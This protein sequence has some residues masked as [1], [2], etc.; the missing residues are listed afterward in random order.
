MGR[1]AALVRKELEQHVAV[2]LGIA[3]F[4]P[5]CWALL[6]LGVF[7]APTTVTYVEVHATM[8]RFFV[9]LTGLAIANR[10]VVAEYHGRTQLFLEALPIGRLEV[11]FVKLGLGLVMLETVALGSLGATLLVASLREPIDAPFV[12]ILAA[13]T[14]AFAL[15]VWCFFFTMGLLGRLRF[16]I[17]LALLMLLLFIGTSTELEL[18]RFGPIALVAEDFP[19]ERTRL[20]TSALLETLTFSAAWIALALVLAVMREGSIAETLAKRMSQREKVTIGMIFFAALMAIGR[21]DPPNE[22]PPFELPEA[23]VAR[24]S[25]LPIEVTYGEGDTRADA[26]ALI[27]RL[28]PELAALRDAL[29]WELLPTIRVA[30]AE[31]LDGSTFEPVELGEDDGVLVR[32]NY[33]RGPEWDEDAFVSEIVGRAID[34]HTGGRALWEPIEWPR[35]GIATWW[36]HRDDPTLPDVIVLRALWATRERGPDA[37]RLHAWDRTLQREGERIGAAL[38]GTGIQTIEETRGKDAVLALGRA[39]FGEELP[40]DSRAV[41]SA[42]LS[43]TPEVLHDT[44]GLSEDELVQRWTGWLR[45]ARARPPLAASIG[46]LPYGEATLSFERADDGALPTLV[47]RVTLDRAPSPGTTVSLLH[48]GIGPFDD[49]VWPWEPQ[50]DERAWPEGERTLEIRLPGRYGGAQ[51]AWVSLDVEGTPLG[52]AARVAHARLEAP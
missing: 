42:W 6:L 26:E 34:A 16:A 29:G 36:P 38:A 14:S 11:F 13:R 1:I 46:G 24:S 48:L 52:I 5:A 28:E 12:A 18:L 23:G 25:S 49:Y 3:L 9:V 21:L 50:R 44:T 17:Y 32:A 31:R 35:D 4:L 51:R 8:T 41:V 15:F 45:A 7:A 22:R 10:L 20:P 33:V 30:L 2:L 19:L 43:P 47:A 27:A 40:D 37:A 39:L